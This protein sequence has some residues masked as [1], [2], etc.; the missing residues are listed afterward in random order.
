MDLKPFKLDI[1]ELINEFSESG[2][3]SLAEFKKVW[4]SKKFSFIFEAGPLSN[5]G[6]FMQSLY[7]HC[8]GYMVSAR[9][10]ANRV[11]G[12]YCLHCLYETQPYKPPY[13]IYLSHV[14]LREIKC[15]VADA[16]A[17]DVKIVSALVKNMLDRN[18]FLFG[19]VGVNEGSTT[20]RVDELREIQNAR[21]QAAYK[22]LFADSRLEHFI[23]M[24]MGTELDIDV[25]KKKSSDYAVAK[26]L[27][28]K[29]A[30]KV[31]DVQNMEHIAEKKRLVGDV[32]EK[33]TADW[34]S[35]KEAL[36]KQTGFTRP[37]QME[38]ENNPNNK[39]LTF[40]EMPVGNV[41]EQMQ[42]DPDNFG[43][44]LEEVLMLDQF[45]FPNEGAVDSFEE[46][47]Q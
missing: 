45:E 28:I 33:I 44:E 11:G 3:T 30:S 35:Q 27:A 16:K 21:V 46:N 36:Y 41:D 38:E 26:E 17:A 12:L 32:V 29:E 23:H 47:E 42:D 25:F 43:K 4:L 34:T 7:A 24:D 5:Q 20:E 13:K 31:T 2:S 19:F 10:L 9:T 39:Q 1:D 15:L 37:P 18:A 8:I 6:F 40:N 14:E 22:K